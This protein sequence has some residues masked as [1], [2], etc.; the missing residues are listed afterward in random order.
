V[1]RAIEPRGIERLPHHDFRGPHEPHAAA[2]PHRDQHGIWRQTIAHEFGAD[3]IAS[4][5][6]LE[7]ERVAIAGVRTPDDGKHHGRD[8]NQPA[9]VRFR[10]QVHAH[11]AGENQQHDDRRD[12]EPQYHHSGTANTEGRSQT[13]RPQSESSTRPLRLIP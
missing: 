2:L 3:A 13:R 7:I 1:I 6:S 11:G 8:R 12:E 10:Q 4:L 9:H 5:H